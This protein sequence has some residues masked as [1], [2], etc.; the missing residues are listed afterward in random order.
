MFPPFEKKIINENNETI[1][2]LNERGVILKEFKFMHDSSMPQWIEFPVKNK[3]DFENITF[4]LN[5]DSKDR[6]PDWKEVKKIYKNREYP[7]GLIICGGYAF[8]R[9]LLGMEN[10]SFKYYDDPGLI[11]AI[12]K[13]W[14]YFENAIC[15]HVIEELDIDYVYI[16][17]DMAFKNGPFVSPQIF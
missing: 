5:P 17:E 2:Y 12:T 10:L 6:Y 14:Y 15:E 8:Q 16:W 11:E 1:T 3:T 13:Y 9:E 7:L 4:R